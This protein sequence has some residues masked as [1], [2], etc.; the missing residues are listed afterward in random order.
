MLSFVPR[1]VL[2][3]ILNLIESV[4]EGFPSYSFFLCL[5]SHIG[6]P[7]VTNRVTSILKNPNRKFNQT[8]Q[9][10][11]AEWEGVS[12]TKIRFSRLR[13]RSQ[14]KVKDLSLYKSCVSHHSKTNKE[15]LIKLHRKAK[16]NKKVYRT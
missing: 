13:S 12:H 1:G 15:T 9:N 8:S 5:L 4:S 2:D 6:C 10:G 7:S 3:K 16:Q 14:L 11:K